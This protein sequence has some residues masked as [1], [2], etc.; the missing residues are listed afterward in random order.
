MNLVASFRSEFKK[1][2]RYLF[3]SLLLKLVLFAVS[4]LALIFETG[5]PAKGLLWFAG[6]VQLL[7]FLSRWR[8]MAHQ[9][10]A[11]E[12]RRTAMLRDG[13]GICPPRMYEAKMASRVGDATKYEAQTAGYYT[14]KLPKGPFRLTEITA[15]SAFYSQ[16]IARVSG[17]ILVAVAAGGAGIVV[18][19]FLALVMASP[20]STTLDLASKI[21]VLAVAFWAT[22]DWIVMAIRLF[23]CASGC[24][25]VLDRCSEFLETEGAVTE[26]DAC[27]VLMEYHAAVSG[28]GPLPSFVY[29]IRRKRLDEAW[30]LFA[31]SWTAGTPV[32]RGDP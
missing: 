32:V 30:A 31:G 10:L 14:S 17:W 27:V 3:W 2:E 15:E 29:K 19:S 8:S 20:P 21:A 26:R 7:L 11:E 22:D 12:L 1:S 5:F 23:A 25:R 4:V 18:Y 6:I 24:D 9:D 13:L 28:A 16:D